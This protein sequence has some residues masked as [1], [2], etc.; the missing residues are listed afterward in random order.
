MEGVG[1]SYEV[2]R[3][4]EP[5]CTATQVG[6][7]YKN[8]DWYRVFSGFM[9]HAC[10]EH[11]EKWRANDQAICAYEKERDKAYDTFMDDASDRFHAQYEAEHGKRPE[12]LPAQNSIV[13]RKP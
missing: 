9:R 1:M 10:P 6:G 4:C 5:N 12:T 7:S 3:C 2:R 8:K 11:A 13:E